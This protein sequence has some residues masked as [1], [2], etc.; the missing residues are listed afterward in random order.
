MHPMYSM[1]RSDPSVGGGGRAPERSGAS[2]CG[3]FSATY[4]R[5]VIGFLAIIVLEACLGLIP[6]LLIRQIIDHALPSKDTAEVTLLAG[7]MIVAAFADA[8][9]SL[10]E[11]W[12]S[13]TIG[14]GLIYDL[15]SALF[16]HV[17]RMPHRLLHPHPDRCARSAA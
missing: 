2:R 4:H 3:A 5:R 8:G 6:P 10:V 12:L 9:L 11:R 7:V 15:R 14:E 13:A 17:Q 16:D 1:M